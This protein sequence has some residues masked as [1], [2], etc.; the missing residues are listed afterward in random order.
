MANLIPVTQLIANAMLAELGSNNSLLLTGARTYESDFRLPDYRVGDTISLRRQNQFLV[1]DGRVGV[2]Q[3]TIERV[4][5]LTIS[6][7]LNVTTEYSSRELTLFV[8]TGEGAFN[9]RYIRP[10]INNITKQA[11]TLIAQGAVNQLNFTSGNPA[12]PINSWGI[13]DLVYA[14][15]MEQG[16]QINND[17]YGALSPR[18]GSNLKNSAQNFFNDTLN[19][20]ISFASR[21]GHYSVFDIFQNQSVQ[22]HTVGAGAVGAVVAVT[23]ASGASTINLSGLGASV[24]G[25]YL[26]GDIIR[27]DSVNSVN[28]IDRSDTGQLMDFVVQNQVDST[29]GGLGQVIVSPPIISDPGSPYRN[30]SI[31]VVA[32]M[33]VTLEGAPGSRYHVNPFYAPRGLDIV[34]P[35]LEV[36]NSVD[37]AVV[38]DKD[39]NVS[40]RVE[41]QGSLLNDINMLRVD[42]LFGF[43]WHPDYAVRLHS[44]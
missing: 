24:V 13:L 21:L 44:L 11:E 12:A 37:T 41:R 4:E 29:A 16:I 1:N 27:F 5:P 38:T 22:F 40:L 3:D 18:Q 7:Q 15:M 35:P 36:L 43:K 25:V 26:P 34:I 42:M 32:T 20:D 9:E 31:P 28:P 19:E 30:V 6:H 33:P 17:G 14:K 2:V 10:M 39:L 23:P 8:D